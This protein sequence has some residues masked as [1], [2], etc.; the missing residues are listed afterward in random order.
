LGL[1]DEA[2]FAVDCNMFGGHLLIRRE[3][4]IGNYARHAVW[5]FS[6][7]VGIWGILSLELLWFNTHSVVLLCNLSSCDPSRLL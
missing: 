2:T 4:T 5:V 6:C 3:T 7:P 1:V